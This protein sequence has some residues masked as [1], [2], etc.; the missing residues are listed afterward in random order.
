MTPKFMLV[1]TLLMKFVD[2]CKLM[3]IGYLIGFIEVLKLTVNNFKT[4]C[5]LLSSNCLITEHV[6]NIEMYD[7]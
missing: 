2:P 5:M 1:V 7:Y 4:N 6:L 3:L